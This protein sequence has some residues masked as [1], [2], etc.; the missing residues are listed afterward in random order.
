MTLP[1]AI[2]VPHAGV[3][4]PQEAATYCQLT[5]EQII[6]D[7]DEGAAEIYDLQDEVAEFITTDIARA[8]VDLNR[9]VEDRGPDG[10]VKTHTIWKEPVYREP[11]SRDI[12]DLLLGR[13]YRPYHVRL[14]EV[15]GCGLRFAVD[16]HTMAAEAPPIGPDPGAKR[17]EVCIGNVHGRSFPEAW[18]TIFH[19]AFQD[20]FAGFHVILNQPFAGGYITQTHS[21]E[22]PWVQIELSRS[23]FLPTCEIR[24][25]VIRAL[26]R[27]CRKLVG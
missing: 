13:Y 10:V 22:M 12:I 24:E 5:R 1:I 15:S 6:K 23:G 19:Q 17:P 20:A 26:Q 16:C 4:I 27:T 7:G 3:R 2:S 18:T 9:S 21:S 14:S 11:L 8:V 25:R